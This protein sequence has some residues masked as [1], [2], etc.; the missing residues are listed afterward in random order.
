MSR[1]TPR[2]AGRFY[3]HIDKYLN[4]LEPIAAC[5]AN[6]ALKDCI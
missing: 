1:C 3:A 5:L 4:D 2:Q 6:I